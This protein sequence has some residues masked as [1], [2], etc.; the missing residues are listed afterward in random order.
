M[1]RNAVLYKLR[2]RLL[3]LLVGSNLQITIKANGDCKYQI[4]VCDSKK[5][6]PLIA[7]DLIKNGEQIKILN[8]AYGL[9][10]ID[11]IKEK[12]D[13]GRVRMDE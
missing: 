5:R 13:R 12:A 4:D 1:T 10:V 11:V 7:F 9:K 6:M 8:I 2:I 3:D